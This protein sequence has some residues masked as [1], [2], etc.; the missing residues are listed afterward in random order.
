MK[1]YLIAT[2]FL[3]GIGAAGFALA[4]DDDCNVAMSNWQPREAVKAMAE[5][6]GW[7][8]RRIKTDDGC[9]EI[10][11]RD[12]QGREIEVKVD[13]GTLA[14][15]E[16]EYEDDDDDDDGYGKSGKNAAPVGPV[17]PPDN[18]LFTPG[19]KPVVKQ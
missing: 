14:I 7:S 4:D 1:K 17:T 6:Q 8:V 3:A 9:Y 19:S 11:G 2:T 5:A 12:A 18:G 10:D 15:V 13:P 16:M